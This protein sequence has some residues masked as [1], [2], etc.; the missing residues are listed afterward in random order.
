M[1]LIKIRQ[2]LAVACLEEVAFRQGCRSTEEVR[3]LALAYAEHPRGADL[4]EPVR[5]VAWS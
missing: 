2:V 4:A 1:A 3:T 5:K